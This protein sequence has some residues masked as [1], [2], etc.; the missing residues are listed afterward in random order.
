MPS[1]RRPEMLP[2]TCEIVLRPQLGDY[3]VEVLP[4]F[5]EGPSF[6]QLHVTY[7]AASGYA[8]GLRMCLGLKVH[9]FCDETNA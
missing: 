5:T 8:G 3:L 4:P 9:D 6:D 1:R 7:K 2:P